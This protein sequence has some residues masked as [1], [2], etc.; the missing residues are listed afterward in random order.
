VEHRDFRAHWIGT[1]DV[2]AVAYDRLVPGRDRRAVNTLRLWSPK[3][4]QSI[5]LGAFNSGRFIEA[6]EPKARWK[7]I[8]RVLYPDDSTAEG[9][10]LRLR[11]EY[12]FASASVQDVLARFRA[13]HDDWRLLPEKV[14]IH[15]NDTHPAL[16]PAE[17]M[18]LLVD[19]H[20]VE[21]SEAWR[22]TQSVFTYT[23]HTL[24]PEALENWPVA[25][26]HRV[27]PRHLEIIAEIDRR[28]LH[29]V[30][31]RRGS[32]QNVRR[33]VC[34]IQDD[35]ERRVNM[36]RLSALASRR[37]NGVSNLHSRLVR[38][39]LFADF[40]SLY[41]DRFTNVT[42][43]I[44]HRRWL[45]QSNPRLS[46]L[47]DETIG[48][49]WRQNLERLTELGRFAED[50]AFGE[51][52][53]QVKRANKE[54]LASLIAERTGL[55]VDPAA[56]FDV[57]VKRI[58]EYKRQLLNI[59]GV[60][61]R[62]NAIRA[63][64]G[65]VWAPR[66]VVM[67]GKAASAYWMAKQIIKLAHDVGAR[68]NTDPITGDR[69]KLIFLPNYNVSLAEV[70]IP[71]AN[72]SQQISLAGTEASGTG[73][74]KLALN[75]ALTLG[76]ADGANI[77][78][79]EVVGRENVFKFG[80][81]VEEAQQLSAQGYEPRAIYSRDDRVRE[82][83]DQIA[84]GAFSPG[85]ADRFRAIVDALLQ[86]GDRYLVLADFASYWAAQNDVDSVW[87]QPEVWTARTVR[88]IA[89]MGAFS[90]DRAIREYAERIWKADF[91]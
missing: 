63:E 24:M 48:R 38:E 82:V 14:A 23:N 75:G 56:L 67:A 32:D 87:A 13:E 79:A 66:I 46:R 91:L 19:E 6:L 29:Q 43:G 42:N 7:T 64:P 5:D 26:L 21:W 40:A 17:L 65:R 62:W 41:P 33:R 35:G 74:M 8:A 3:P 68:I 11:Q 86:G 49:G 71:A 72:L 80:L 55:K 47:I 18:R 25:L 61:A 52:M 60:V 27:L 57:Q 28:F 44:A 22:L 9:R 37:V 36:G 89:G 76:T 20:R 51:R 85:E 77:E 30:E 59:L 53:Q 81:G 83:L 34:V 16:A 12:F 70:I 90:S 50:A 10:E 69:L 45:V 4:L 84:G 88:N 39:Q 1:D 54:R 15:L 78:I 58:H 31:Q 2:F 73:N